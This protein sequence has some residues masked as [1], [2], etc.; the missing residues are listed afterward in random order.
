ML[1][2]TAVLSASIVCHLAVNNALN[3]G[4]SPLRFRNAV[5][6]SK[7]LVSSQTSLCAGQIMP[8]TQK[9][10]TSYSTTRDPLKPLHPTRKGQRKLHDLK[11]VVSRALP[12][13]IKI[14]SQSLQAVHPFR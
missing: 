2:S 14:S 8:A 5:Q 6:L 3:T 9:K 4:C 1:G 11:K 13:T 10:L 7:A 12:L